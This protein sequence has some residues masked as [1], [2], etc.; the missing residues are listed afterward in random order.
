MKICGIVGFAGALREHRADLCAAFAALIFDRVEVDA[1]VRHADRVEELAHRPAELAPLQREHHHRFGGD[2]CVDEALRLGV[3]RDC[4]RR[5]RDLHR[6]A[7]RLGCVW[8]RQPGVEFDSA[9]SSA[10]MCSPTC[11]NSTVD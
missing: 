9:S 11:S 1:G 2:G 5:R 6:R 8:K 7:A 4:G 10:F 3:E